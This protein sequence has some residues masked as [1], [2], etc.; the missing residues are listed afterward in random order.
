MH[1]GTARPAGVT[2]ITAH[3]PAATLLTQIFGE[4]ERTSVAMACHRLR[5]S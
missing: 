3:A 2:L 1:V 4:G 5:Q